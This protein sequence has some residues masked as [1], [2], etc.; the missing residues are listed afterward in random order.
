MI[1]LS[2]SIYPSSF[3]QKVERL[4]TG[5]DSTWGRGWLNDVIDHM[6]P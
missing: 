1:Y 5:G 4:E 2:G 3:D 6:Y